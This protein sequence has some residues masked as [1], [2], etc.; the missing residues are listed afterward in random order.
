[1]RA[2]LPMTIGF[3]VLLRDCAAPSMWLWYGLGNIGLFY[4][5]LVLRS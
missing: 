5:P 4:A 2:V 3:N 1:V